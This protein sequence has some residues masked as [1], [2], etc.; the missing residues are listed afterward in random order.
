M[1][2]KQVVLVALGLLIAAPVMAVGLKNPAFLKSTLSRAQVTPPI[3]LYAQ[4]DTNNLNIPPA[5]SQEYDTNPTD[6]PEKSHEALNIEYD[7][8][9]TDI[10]E[11][12][13]NNIRILA[14]TNQFD[15]IP[16]ASS[17]DVADTNN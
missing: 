3:G 10:P 6:I 16:E 13:H 12:T 17:Q 5:V 14:D 4:Q 9:P 15:E 11:P 8:N 2:S 1:N 7:T